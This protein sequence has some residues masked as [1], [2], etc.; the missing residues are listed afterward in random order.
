M[1][2]L[3]FG[4]GVTNV[5]TALET[6]FSADAIWGQIEPFIPVVITV[7]LVSLSIYFI[8]RITKKVS[9]GKG[10]M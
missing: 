4:A 8:R 6:G 1:D 5:S 7:T 3:V 10:G 2:A 9:K